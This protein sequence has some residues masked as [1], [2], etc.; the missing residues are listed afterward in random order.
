M[1]VVLARLGTG[2]DNSHSRRRGLRGAPRLPFLGWATVREQ[3]N[4]LIESEEL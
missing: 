1:A 3:L 4:E 2:G